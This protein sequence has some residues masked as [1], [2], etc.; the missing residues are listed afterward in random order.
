MP[1]VISIQLFFADLALQ[2]CYDLSTSR[3]E[4]R[5]EKNQIPTWVASSLPAINKLLS[6]RWNFWISH[7]Q[8]QRWLLFIR[9]SANPL[10]KILTTHGYF[11]VI[12]TVNTCF[13]GL[14]VT[15]VSTGLLYNT[16]VNFDPL[17]KLVCFY[18]FIF[19][20]KRDKTTSKKWEMLVLFEGRIMLFLHIYKSKSSIS[21]SWL[22]KWRGLACGSLHGT[23][24]IPVHVIH[25]RASTCT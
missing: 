23:L 20:G 11:P 13:D 12:H 2:V 19:L 4:S 14:C 15:L 1:V 3:S 18:L 10:T 24:P 9:T 21:V 17:P 25:V 8:R 7:D 6:E 5:A 16:S 22:L